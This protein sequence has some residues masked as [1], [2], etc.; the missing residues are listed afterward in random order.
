MDVVEV[1]LEQDDSP[2][3]VQPFRMPV[4]DE[5]ETMTRWALQALVE[6]EA[7]QD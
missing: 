3:I 1:D 6:A 2:T 4:N 5:G 7:A